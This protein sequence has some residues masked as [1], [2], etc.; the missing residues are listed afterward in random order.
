[1]SWSFNSVFSVLINQSAFP[2]CFYFQFQNVFDPI[3]VNIEHYPLSSPM[4]L[5][6]P[7]VQLF[8]L[9][10]KSA[11]LTNKSNN[12]IIYGN[13]MYL[14]KQLNG[15][16]LHV[17]SNLQTIISLPPFQTSLYIIEISQILRA[18]LIWYIGQTYLSAN[19]WRKM[20]LEFDSMIFPAETIIKLSY[21]FSWYP[22]DSW[23]ISWIIS[24][25]IWLFHVFLVFSLYLSHFFICWWWLQ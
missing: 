3:N 6:F 19:N 20:M 22:R 9:V 25:K 15:E 18:N 10:P 24:N 12:I 14:R 5:R 8:I 7:F 2:S 17:C 4:P 16:W 13:V 11:W 1:M 23:K 21:V